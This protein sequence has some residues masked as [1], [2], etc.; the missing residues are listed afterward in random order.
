MSRLSVQGQGWTLSAEVDYIDV[1]SSHPSP[2]EGWR[3][4]DSNGHEHRYTRTGFPTLRFVVDASHWC[5]GTEGFAWH[6]PHEI[7][8]EWHYECAQCGEVIEPATD[9]PFTPKSVP[10]TVRHT[11]EGF[12]SDGSRVTMWLDSD[13]AERIRATPDDATALAILDGA[14][15]ERITLRESWA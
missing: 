10:G 1:T 15:D 7:E 4:T 13:E 5:D 12:R 8:D 9:P 2:R 11:L 6:D 14:P 3:M